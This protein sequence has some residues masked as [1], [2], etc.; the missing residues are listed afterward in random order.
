MK[1]TFSDSIGQKVKESLLEQLRTLPVGARLTPERQLAEEFQVSRTTMSKILTELVHEGYLSRKIGSGTYVSPRNTE[2][3]LG[4]LP[5]SDCGELLVVYPDFFSYEF[6]HIIHELEITS[7]RANLHLV[8]LRLHPE[9]DAETILNLAEKCRRLS[10]IILLGGMPLGRP[11]LRELDK[12]D[13]PIVLMSKLSHDNGYRNIR[14]V[15][16]NHIQSGFLKLDLL[17]RNGHRRIGVVMNEPPSSVVQDTL[18][19]M[20][21]AAHA[22]KL[23]WHDLT[24]AGSRIR[25]WE[26]PMQSGYVLAREILRKSPDVTALVVDTIFG[27]FGALRALHE[28]GRR[29]PEDVSI[30]TALSLTGLEGYSVPRLTTVMPVHEK[31]VAAALELILGYR[32]EPEVVID[33]IVVERESVRNLNGEQNV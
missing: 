13:L 32:S 12:L 2:V 18:R 8:N 4:R 24:I 30:V 10:G 25:F 21:Q 29:C 28:A 19:G 1:R 26:D 11:L 9:S 14:C 15:H 5:S 22:H 17:L 3:I 27:A 33:E 23:R 31:L 7:M 20:K 16:S 6:W